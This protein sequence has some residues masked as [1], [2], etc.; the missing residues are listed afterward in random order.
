VSA[1]G[2]IRTAAAD[3]SAGNAGKTGGNQIKG[4]NTPFMWWLE[5]PKRLVNRPISRLQS[6][7]AMPGLVRGALPYT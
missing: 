7:R 1:G 3:F 5:A 4:A 6:S 2:A